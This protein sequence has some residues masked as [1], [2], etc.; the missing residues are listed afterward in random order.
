MH[1]EILKRYVAHRSKYAA[2]T[3]QLRPQAISRHCYQNSSSPVLLSAGAPG[4]D[5]VALSTLT[6]PPSSLLIILYLSVVASVSIPQQGEFLFSSL[7][8]WLA[9]SPVECT[10]AAS[11]PPPKHP[12]NCSFPI[13]GAQAPPRA[14]FSSSV[15]IHQPSSLLVSSFHSFFTPLLSHHFFLTNTHQWPHSL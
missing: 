15:R 6:P 4:K 3:L 1:L 13:G 14:L 11:S 8:F 7:L 10:P 5:R 9:T 2:H 12:H